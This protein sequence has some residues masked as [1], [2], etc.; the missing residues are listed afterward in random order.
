M[1]FPCSLIL[2]S[3]LYIASFYLFFWCV[4]I[5][6]VLFQFCKNSSNMQCYYMLIEKSVHFIIIYNFSV[7]FTAFYKII[8]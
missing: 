6:Y 5:Y 8:Q 2:L 3:L 4:I 7:S 1:E